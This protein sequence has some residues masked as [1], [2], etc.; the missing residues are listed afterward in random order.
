[1]WLFTY[2]L[3][4]RGGEFPIC[5][6]CRAVQL[7]GYTILYRKC[8]ASY[9]EIITVGIIYVKNTSCRYQDMDLGVTF[10]F[11]IFSSGKIVFN[12]SLVRRAV[13]RAQL[14]DES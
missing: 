10:K 9:V 12:F 13:D 5:I 4:L 6:S 8:I 14:K 3:D 1:M 7:V 11:F 2:F